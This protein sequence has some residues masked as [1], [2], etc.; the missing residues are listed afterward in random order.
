[1]AIMLFVGHIE[2]YAIVF[3][4]YMVDF[5]F[6]AKSGMPS[7]GWWGTYR[8]GKLHCDSAPKGFCQW[9]MKYCKGISEVRLV[10]GFIAIEFFFVCMGY[11][12]V[13][14]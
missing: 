2:A 13:T 7:S 14:A 11:V 4:P 12:A 6:K 10:M 5:Y 3:I 9:I 1:M 8:D